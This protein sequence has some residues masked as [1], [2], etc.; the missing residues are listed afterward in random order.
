MLTILILILTSLKAQADATCVMGKPDVTV[1]PA[2]YVDATRSYVSVTIV[3]HTKSGH[4]NHV[5]VHENVPADVILENEGATVVNNSTVQAN[6]RVYYN[7]KGAPQYVLDF[8]DTD[9][10]ASFIWV[11]VPV[12][13]TGKTM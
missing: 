11:D 7:P 9:R 4:C 3:P 2:H 12:T 5:V 10:I 13:F 6:F 1:S 8:H